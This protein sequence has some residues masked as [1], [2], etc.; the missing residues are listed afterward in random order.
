M[1]VLQYLQQLISTV[2]NTLA[3]VSRLLTALVTSGWYLV[4]QDAAVVT[5]DIHTLLEDPSCGQEAQCTMLSTIISDLATLSSD[6]A[7]LGNPQQT[8]SPVTLPTTAPPGYG[9]ASASAIATAVWDTANYAGQAMGDTMRSLV[10]FFDGINSNL[11][12]PSPTGGPFVISANIGPFNVEPWLFTPD[13]G[14]DSILT[15]DADVGA[16]L[17]RVAARGET[18][19]YDSDVEL[20]RTF[21]LGQPANNTTWYCTV[22]EIQFKWVQAQ[23]AGSTVRVP[24]IWPGLANVTLGAPVAFGSGPLSVPGPMHGILVS[25]TSVNQPLPHYWYGTSEAWGKLGGLT[26]VD[27]NGDSEE[28]QLFGFVSAVY[29]PR[30][31]TE[32]TSCQIRNVSGIVGTVTPWTIT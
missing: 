27:D 15:T 9:G 21:G 26:F 19:S 24:P 32:A 18:W 1:S 23:L 30:F 12:F 28:Y 11:A 10:Y 13:Y 2:A 16:W 6:L 8:G 20:W 29:T 7:A 14:L 5:T 22:S 4:I 17:N 31:M 25:I 3:F